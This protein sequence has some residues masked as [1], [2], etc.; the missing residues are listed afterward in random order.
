MHQQ[1]GAGPPF[2]RFATTL[3]PQM[4]ALEHTMENQIITFLQAVG[5]KDFSLVKK[6]LDSGHSPSEPSEYGNTPLCNAVQSKSTEMIDL[7]VQYGADV[8]E[9]I[10][11]KSPVDGRVKESYT[12]LL[13]A[14][15]VSTIHFLHKMGANIN[16]QAPNGLTILM[17]CA[18][19]PSA[20]Y[21]AI[22]KMLLQLGADKNITT[23]QYKGKSGVFT[24][25]DIVL[26]E[27]EFL[28]KLSRKYHNEK[29]DIAIEK[30][31]K[32]YELLA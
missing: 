10:T 18:V 31:S 5:E 24:A 19:V 6:M 27:Q 28:N 9:L 29:M 30:L 4:A 23:N 17:I 15:D 32:M 16:Y 22:V 11:Y 20:E 8:N 13:F 25:A 21:I 14:S 1:A 7:L 12:P 26:V 3:R 2:R